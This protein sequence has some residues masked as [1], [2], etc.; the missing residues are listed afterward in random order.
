MV[1]GAT[2]SAEAASDQPSCAPAGGLHESG[3]Q[4]VYHAMTLEQ[5]ESLRER[6]MAALSP[7]ESARLGREFIRCGDGGDVGFAVGLLGHYCP[8]AVW[9]RPDLTNY[10]VTTDD[11]IQQIREAVNRLG[12]V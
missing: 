8:I 12:Q 11:A 9:Y 3:V 6:V 7:D 1:G 4:R 5:C 10:G 2:C